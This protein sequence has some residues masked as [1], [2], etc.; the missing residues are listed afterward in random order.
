M[1]SWARIGYGAALLAVPNPVLHLAS[2]QAATARER[3][4]TRF[5]GLRLLTQ[6]AV[7]AV[8]PDAATLAVS[9]ETDFV[10]AATMLAWAAVDRRSRRLTLLSG[11]LAALFGAVDAM[12]ARRAPTEPPCPTRTGELL[13]TL[14]SLRHRAAAQ[15]ARHT[16]PDAVRAGWQT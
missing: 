11:V 3:A 9:A 5:L 16:L 4:V 7:T 13:P 6:G 15:V 1:I 2:G 8:A 12:R 10:H 14:V